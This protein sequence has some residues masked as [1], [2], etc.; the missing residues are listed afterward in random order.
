MYCFMRSNYNYILTQFCS[1]WKFKH[2]SK[3]FQFIN[4]KRVITRKSLYS[5]L[6]L[7]FWLVGNIHAQSKNLDVS[8]QLDSM[9]Y[10]YEKHPDKSINFHKDILEKYKD[11]E[12][13]TFKTMEQLSDFYFKIGKMGEA[14]DLLE[15]VNAHFT[16]ISDFKSIVRTSQKLGDTYL[17]DGKFGKAIRA[18]KGAIEMQKSSGEFQ[19]IV[20]TYYQL[21]ISLANVLQYEKSIYNLKK[22]YQLSISEKDSLY[23]SSALPAISEM[24]WKINEIDSAIHYN[25]KAV[26]NNYIQSDEYNCHLLTQQSRLAGLQNK[27]EKALKYALAAFDLKD[28]I[29]FLANIAESEFQL[30]IAY[31]DL[32]DYSNARTH[33]ESAINVYKQTDLSEALQN[34]YLYLYRINVK[35]NKHA[36]A[37]ESMKS[38][39]KYREENEIDIKN[40]LIQYVEFSYESQKKDHQLAMQELKLAKQSNTIQNQRTNN[41]VFLAGGIILFLLGILLSFLLKRRMML[42]NMEIE[43]LEQKNKESILEARAK[44]TD[45]ERKRL[46][47][48]LHDS[49]SGDLAAIKFKLAEISNENLEPEESEAKQVAIK[50]LDKTSNEIRYISHNLSSID[51][52]GYNLVESIKRLC[53]RTEDAFDTT[54]NF[55]FFGSQLHLTKSNQNELYRTVQEIVHNITKHAN[56]Q[57][58]LIQ[59]NHHENELQIL[60]EDDG[61]GFDINKQRGGL[62]IKSIRKRTEKLGGECVFESDKHGTS[63][64]L[65]YK[66]NKMPK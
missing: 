14:A 45:V 62:G 29:H 11:D 15:T 20:H 19:N 65:T 59:M 60:V 37:K 40:K 30:G 44:G 23:L 36:K 31:F 7:C 12:S 35:Q 64:Q 58:V 52:L 13:I 63:V 9:Y 1:T 25:Q 18:Y 55:Q 50:L 61:I 22:A 34:A 43:R 56:A 28:S 16:R 27:P 24:Y 46:A 33:I 41:I 51:Q 32:L 53:K 8:T 47:R 3:P 4:L 17:H 21:G 6:F 48:D 49:I 26:A 54:Y 42:N 66:L 39:K 5:I 57:E 38:Y 2:S 10:N